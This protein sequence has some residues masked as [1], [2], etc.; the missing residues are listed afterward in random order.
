MVYTVDT[1]T[2]IWHTFGPRRKLS[3]R[4]GRILEDTDRGKAHVIIPIVVLVEILDLIRINALAVNFHQMLNDL[5]RAQNYSVRE[6]GVEIMDEAGYLSAFS[7]L[8][9][10]L[11]VAT[12]RHLDLPLI[13]RDE[14]ISNSGLIETIW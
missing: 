12:A 10:R 13:T 8:R 11:I 9:D 3:K 1:H 4:A 7:D 6:L 2:F 14:T 5:A